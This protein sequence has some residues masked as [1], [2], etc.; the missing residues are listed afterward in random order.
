M[1]DAQAKVAV[2]DALAKSSSSPT[3]SARSA[4]MAIR[5]RSCARGVV[6]SFDSSSR[7]THTRN[8]SN[9]SV[10]RRSCLVE[11][12]RIASPFKISTI[13]STA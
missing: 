8:A 2:R 7:R 13:L 12:K 4:N 1:S 11:S 10:P 3:S 5:I 9:A 6:G